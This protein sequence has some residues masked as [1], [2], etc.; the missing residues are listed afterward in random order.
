[1]SMLSA[2]CLVCLW[3]HAHASSSRDI[4]KISSVVFPTAPC[5]WQS[6]VLFGSCLRST[7]R[8]SGRSL[9][10]TSYSAL[11]G[12][13]EDTYVCQ[14]SVEVTV[15]VFQRIAWSSVVHAMPS[16]TEFRRRHCHGAEGRYPWSKLFV[17][18]KKFSS[19]LVV[20]VV[21]LP[22]RPCRKLW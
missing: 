10:D 4:W 9:P 18:P 19:C 11:L 20:Q 8:G 1:M 17:G 15:S 16:V 3:I 12:S 5:I 7:V 21:Q 14:S 22:G 2:P 6:L 13:T